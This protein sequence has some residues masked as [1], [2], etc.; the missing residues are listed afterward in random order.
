LKDSEVTI[1]RQKISELQ[2]LIE[3]YQ[4]LSQQKE[5]QIS[6]LQDKVENLE[7]SKKR[8]SGNLEYLKNIIVKYMETNDIEG[9]L[10]VI[11]TILQFSPDEL[12][13][14]EQAHKGVFTKWKL[15]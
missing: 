15:W 12:Q 7:R 8:E 2:E 3:E 11:S 6:T 14:I 10:P 13:R 5:N 9:L 1:A 4:L